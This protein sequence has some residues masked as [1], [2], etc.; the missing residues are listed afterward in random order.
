M[1]PSL[2]NRKT[3]LDSY[4][5]SYARRSLPQLPPICNS[6]CT[7]EL[8]SCQSLGKSSHFERFWVSYNCHLNQ[9]IWCK[10]WC[11][12][13][14][15]TKPHH[16]LSRHHV[17]CPRLPSRKCLL[18]RMYN[19]MHWHVGWGFPKEL[20][21]AGVRLRFTRHQN[22]WS[23]PHTLKHLIEGKSWSSHRIQ[24]AESRAGRRPLNSQVLKD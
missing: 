18:Q 21:R 20:P 16:L 4:H 2:D 17:G 12:L 14:G 13:A 11:F 3:Q 7:W 19:L 1:K 9:P 5:A 22:G 23:I 10:G 24:Q 15:F 6:F 8:P